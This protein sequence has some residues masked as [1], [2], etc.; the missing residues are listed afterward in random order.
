[1]KKCA[2]YARV[3]TV[4][5]RVENQLYDLRQFAAKRGYEVVAEYTDIGVSGAKARRQGLDNMLRDA[6]KHKFGVILVASFDRIA[7]STKH[8]LQV[9]D[10]LESLEVKFVSRREDVS[11]DGSMGRLFLTMIASIAELKADLIRERIK[12]GMRRRKLEGLPCGRTPLDVDRNAIVRDRLAGLSLTKCA[13]KYGV[14][15]A[16]VLRF[17]GKAQRQ[18]ITA[19][20]ES[21]P[22]PVERPSAGEC[23]A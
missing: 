17:V 9:V 20:G 8:F 14:S 16:S 18:E 19:L 4:E 3:S 1:M 15:R 10:E 13:R 21:I 6:R 2:I 7:R 11:T 22:L 23:V 5:Q 12:A